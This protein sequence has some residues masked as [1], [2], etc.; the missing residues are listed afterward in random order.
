MNSTYLRSLTVALLLSSAHA[1]CDEL[2]TNGNF[3]AGNTG[4]TSDYKFV[5]DSGLNCN[6]SG[7]VYTIGTNP[8]SCSGSLGSFGPFDPSGNMMIVNHNA[9]PDNVV[10]WSETVSVVPN[11]L[12]AFSAYIAP[13][14][15]YSNPVRFTVNGTQVGSTVDLNSGMA[16]TWT[17]FA[18]TWNSLQSTTAVL[19]IVLD[20]G[21]F[22]LDDVSFSGPPTGT[23]N[24]SLPH[25]AVGASY[26]TGF[27]L[28]NSGAMPANFSINFYDD[29]GA[30]L[31]LQFGGAGAAAVLSG[32]IPG[33][34]AAY[35]ETGDPTKPLSPGSAILHAGSQITAQAVFRRLGPDGNYYEA[36]VP[37]TTGGFEFEIPFDATTF[38]ANG[39]QIYT[40][41]A[42]ANLDPVN[43][44]N[45]TCNAHD[46]SGNPIANAVN[47]PPLK[48]LGH[49]ADYLF[50][51]LYGLRGTL[52]CSSNAK[53][54]SIGIRAFGSTISSLSVIQIR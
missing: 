30:P 37:S 41:L 42:I 44:A 2:V 43:T 29:T 36:A 45:V 20:G 49:W 3:A 50:P 17:K 34:G 19:R 51:A 12:Y 11:S 39:L 26:A 53:I 27:Y 25:I 23:V 21:A 6:Q 13:A 52:D 35:Y 47:V 28:V 38:P 32:T 33:N 31:A 5:D 8:S 10:V 40:G 15:P 46:A 22:A 18:A 7:G 48:P 16:G 54:G 4:F 14:T 1:W 9:A 24:R